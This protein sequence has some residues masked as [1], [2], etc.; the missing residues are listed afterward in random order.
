MK[1]TCPATCANFSSFDFQLSKRWEPHLQQLFFTPTRHIYQRVCLSFFPWQK[2]YSTSGHNR[3]LKIMSGDVQARSGG[4][5]LRNR[6]KKRFQD[7][8]KAESCCDDNLV[9]GSGSDVKEVSYLSI[10]FE[11]WTSY[12]KLEN[13]MLQVLALSIFKLGTILNFRVRYMCE[14]LSHGVFEFQVAG[15]SLRSNRTK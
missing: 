6:N 12:L 15:T 1:S 5:K 2:N 4:S 8:L 3:K 14:N 13:L 7:D 10:T 11:A 9:N